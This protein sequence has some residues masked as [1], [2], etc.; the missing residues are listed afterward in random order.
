[1]SEPVFRAVE[2]DLVRGERTLL[3]QVTFT[4]RAGEHWALLG[5]NG[6]GKSTLLR[7]LATYLHPTRGRLDVLGRR[8]G[9]VDVFTLR[10]LI[11]LVTTHLPVRPGRTVRDVVLTGA[12]GTIEL[13]PRWT[14]SAADLARAGAAT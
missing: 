11:G 1:M 10:P 14:P 8:L 4:V 5:A 2:V 6:A 3:S 12:A 13:P 9:Q 7:L